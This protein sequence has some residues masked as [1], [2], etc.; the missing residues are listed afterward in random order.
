M[1]VTSASVNDYKIK[2]IVLWVGNFDYGVK[3]PD[4]MLRIWKMIE[5]HCPDWELYMLGDG[6]SYDICKR[7][8]R[9]LEL[10][11]VRFLGRL[12][13]DKYYHE[14]QILCL[15]SVHECFP[16]VLLEGMH[17]GLALL[18]FDSF[19]SAS[20]LVKE[21]Q[22]GKLITPFDIEQYAK[23]LINVIKDEDIRKYFQQQ[24]KLA[25]EMFNEDQIYYKWIQVINDIKS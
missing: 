25:A 7:M 21:F 8:S 1:H 23:E 18:A 11:N 15:T 16:M 10:K 6:P 12:N 24:S 3:R 22:N 13:P 5:E 19:T 4:N 20:L 9:E 2:K 14:A 17:N